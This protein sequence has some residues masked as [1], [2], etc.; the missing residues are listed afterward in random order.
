MSYYS[1]QGGLLKEGANTINTESWTATGTAELAD[2]TTTAS[3]GHTERIATVDSWELQFK[4]FWTASAPT[5]AP[6]NLMPGTTVA[7]TGLIGGV[8]ATLS[9][10]FIVSN[11]SIETAAKGAVSFSGTAQSNGAVTIS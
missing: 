3:S 6:L 8:P 7:F 4:G 1:G 5:G 11:L 2:V 9:G 10:S